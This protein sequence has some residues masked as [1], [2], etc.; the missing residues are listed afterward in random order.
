MAESNR[1][2]KT[3]LAGTIKVVNSKRETGPAWSEELTG[4]GV[5]EG[6]VHRRGK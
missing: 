3:I 5:D 6:D 4:R 1:V 2:V